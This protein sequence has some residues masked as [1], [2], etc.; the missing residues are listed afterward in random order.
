MIRDAFHGSELEGRSSSSS[1]TSSTDG[2]CCRRNAAA[3][4]SSFRRLTAA[5]S[6]LSVEARLAARKRL[7]TPRGRCSG[8]GLLWDF[9]YLL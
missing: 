9:G 1:T 5:G 2:C 4:S 7:R 6:T 3:S 8:I